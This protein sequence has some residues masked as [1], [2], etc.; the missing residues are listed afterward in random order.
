MKPIMSTILLITGLFNYTS[1]VVAYV[2]PG[3]GAGAIAAALGVIGSIILGLFAI[4]FYPIKRLIRKIKGESPDN[5]S[6]TKSA[7]HDNT[8]T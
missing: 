1:S 8:D 7:Q 4:L 5:P 3:L 2:G 6:R